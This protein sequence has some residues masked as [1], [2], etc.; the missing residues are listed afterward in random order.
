MRSLTGVVYHYNPT[1]N[2]NGRGSFRAEVVLYIII[3]L[4]QTATSV[5][6]APAAY[7]LYIIIILHQ[8]ATIEAFEKAKC[9]LYIIIILHQTATSTNISIIIFKLYIIIILHQTATGSKDKAT[10]LCCIS[11]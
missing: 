11:L 5:Y 8:T 10:A 3:I 1:S 6:I 4:H 2:R 7:W 9:R